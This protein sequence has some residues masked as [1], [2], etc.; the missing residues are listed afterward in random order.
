MLIVSKEKI[1]NPI[2]LLGGFLITS[3]AYDE[4][5]KTIKDSFKRDIYILDITRKDWIQTNS[6]RGW[7]IILN[8]LAKLIYEISNGDKDKK[9][10]LIG[11][12]SGG[13][14]LRIFL[15]DKVF[16]NKIYNGREIVSNLITLGSP[17]Q[18]L[19]ATKLRKFVDQQY[20]GNFFKEVNYVSIG[21]KLGIN[22]DRTTL[23]TKL[24]AKK[25]YTSISGNPEEDG[26]GLVP[27]SASLLQ[28][29]QKIIISDTTHSAIFGKNWYGTSLKTKEWFSQINWR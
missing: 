13:I 3:E 9:I 12:S 23:I 6:I 22:S 14:I 19:K 7:S 24:L 5:Q 4:I 29:S 27:L 28:G 11:H 21:G 18:A 10:D 17:H 1:P 2:I 26:D 16:N 25:F 20:P 15:S 8:K